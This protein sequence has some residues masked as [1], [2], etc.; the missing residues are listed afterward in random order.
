M[1]R[2]RPERGGESEGAERRWSKGVCEILGVRTERR[3]ERQTVNQ[4][5]EEACRV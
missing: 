3:E 4:C 5:K 2:E 1:H